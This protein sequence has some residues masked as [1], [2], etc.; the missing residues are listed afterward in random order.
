MPGLYRRVFRAGVVVS[1]STC[2]VVKFLPVIHH[3][4]GAESLPAAAVAVAR[5]FAGVFLA[6]PVTLFRF[7]LAGFLG[8]ATPFL[9]GGMVVES[10]GGTWFEILLERAM[11]LQGSIQR[12]VGFD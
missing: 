2:L 4:R 12:E 3:V 8:V 5:C 6:V 10:A 1:S 7:R 9:L 11:G